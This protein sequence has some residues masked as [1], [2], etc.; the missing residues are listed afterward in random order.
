MEKVACDASLKETG[1]YVFKN[2]EIDAD[3]QTQHFNA[4]KIQRAFRKYKALRVF[5]TYQCVKRRVYYAVITYFLIMK[6]SLPIAYILM[7]TNALE[8]YAQKYVPPTNWKTRGLGE[9]MMQTWFQKN[10]HLFGTPHQAIIGSHLITGLCVG[11]MALCM[12]YSRPFGGNRHIWMGRLF[13]GM[14]VLHIANG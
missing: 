7:R 12:L 13:I 8:S 10:D 14:W 11:P 2:T 4:R 5:I 6:F 9:G 3:L 1:K